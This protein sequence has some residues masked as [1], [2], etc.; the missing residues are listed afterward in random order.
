MRKQK[1]SVFKDKYDRWVGVVYV[2]VDGKKKPKRF[3]GDSS[4]PDDVQR[5]ELWSK[6]NT[7]LYEIDKGIFINETSATLENYLKEWH[8]VYTADLAETTQELY[9]MYIK[10]HIVPFFEQKKIKDIVQTDIKKWLNWLRG[11]G[12]GNSIGKLYTFLNRVFKDAL[13]DDKIR[14]NP[15]AGLKKPNDEEYEATLYNEKQLSNLLNIVRDTF[16]EVVILIAATGG[17]RRGEIF[18]INP[19]RDLDFENC[20]ISIQETK[21]RFMTK[22]IKAPKT[23]KSKRVISVPFFVMDVINK[24]LNNLSKQPERLCDCMEPQSYSEHFKKLLERNNLPHIRLHDL[25]HFNA[26]IM[27]EYGIPDKEAQRRLGHSQIDTLKRRYQ[28]S[29]KSMQDNATKVIEKVFTE[30][31]YTNVYINDNIIN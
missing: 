3:W 8:K 30:N 29:N 2:P 22:K 1:G 25:R 28:H 23:K 27:L 21:V 12:L 18:G 5:D 7:V 26:T 4:K 13:L 10:N 6:I 14:K 19:K 16:D 31:I 17:L 20:L 15:F 24:Y 11:K 9:S